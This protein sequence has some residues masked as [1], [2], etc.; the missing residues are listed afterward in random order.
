MISAISREIVP[1]YLT[2]QRPGGL[3]NQK[4]EALRIRPQDFNFTLTS[5]ET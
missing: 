1:I 4:K 5:Y 2:L 3:G